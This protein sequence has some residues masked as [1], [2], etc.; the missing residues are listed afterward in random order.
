MP[1]VCAAATG[2]MEWQAQE[3]RL[4]VNE[5]GQVAGLHDKNR[6]VEYSAAGQASPL[7]QV[8]M[9]GA[10]RKPDRM[11]WDAAQK[12]LELH[13]GELR[14]VIQTRTKATHISLELV[15]LTPIDKV[16]R[17]QWG[18]IA[19]RIGQTVGEVIG[20]VR[21]DAFA[22]GLQVLNVK[23]L[24]GA[25]LNDEGR[26]I[27]RSQTAM[28]TEW[29]STLQAYSIDRSRP[30]KV[31]V[32]GNH[33]PNMPVPPIPG[34]TVP[35]C[36]ILIEAE[37]LFGLDSH[38]PIISLQGIPSSVIVFRILQPILASTLCDANPLARIA[39][40]KMIL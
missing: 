26:D 21:D 40:P 30:R 12:Q 15:K 20:V 34:E 36:T 17:V 18:P 25:S 2:D 38:H 23:T 9:D 29:G 5:R 22:I 6:G 33:Y 14:A 39:G 28:P 1:L 24:G 37:C 3:F 31:T 8:R 13:Y 4:T 11:E 27:S 32:W 35:C 7:L 10:F 16:D 19:I